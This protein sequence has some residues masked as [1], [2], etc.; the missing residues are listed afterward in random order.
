MTASLLNAKKNQPIKEDLVVLGEVALSGEIRS[1]PWLE[2]RVNE[3][4]KLG[5]TN[6][7]LPKNK[8]PKQ[9]GITIT[10]CGHIGEVCRNVE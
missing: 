6:F 4:I 1:V 9:D 3:A 8:I 2:N 5:Y 7:I 10:Q